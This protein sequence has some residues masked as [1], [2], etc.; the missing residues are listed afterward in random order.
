MFYY[1]F[2]R[3][4]LL[5][6]L[7]VAL[8]A[9]LASAQS[10][11]PDQIVVELIPG[12]E[13]ED[14]NG[15]WGTSTIDQFEDGLLNLLDASG[16]GDIVILAAQMT[17]DPDVLE[18]EPNFLEDTPEGVRSMVVTAIGGEF[19]DFE[20]QEL[21]ERISLDLAHS[22]TRGLGTLVAILDSGIDP[23]HEVFAGRVA[24]NGYDFVD[25]DSEPWEEADGV[26]NDGDDQIDEGYGHGTMVAG[27]VL[28]VAPEA[29]VLPIRVLDDDGRSDAYR[30]ARAIRYAREQGADIMNLSFGSPVGISFLQTELALAELDDIVIVAGAG[31]ESR[32]EPAYFPGE[33]SKAIMITALDSNDVKADFADWNQEV[34]V[35][36]PGTGVR[37]AYP[38][39][40]WALG[41]GCS[42]ATP[43]V[44]GMAALI[45]AMKPTWNKDFVEDRIEVSVDEI[46]GIPGNQAYDEMLGSGRID[47]F[48]AVTGLATSSVPTAELVS[49]IRALPNPSTGEVRFQNLTADARPFPVEVLDATGRILRTIEPSR[50]GDLAWDGRDEMGREVSSGVYFYR[51][52]GSFSVFQGRVTIFR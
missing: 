44:S 20:D 34:F 11:V 14:V 9:S 48:E 17:G 50:S 5:Q 21:T 46:Y 4:T 8:F 23:D 1:R 28:L 33:S 39:G 26:D 32:E 35:S 51:G 7:G 22:V 49:S 37:S 30:V 45:R 47:V 12:A 40:E 6:G 3:L 31:N 29:T 2:L 41:A 16:L 36:A 15:R 27:L 43:L 18:A 19:V 13:I 52:V 10:Y 42:F 25:E 38:G 24:A